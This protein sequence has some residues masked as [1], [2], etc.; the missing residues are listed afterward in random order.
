[1]RKVGVWIDHTR[2]VVAAIDEGKET[3]ETVESHVGRH[4]KPRGGAGT[5]TPWAPRSPDREHQRERQYEQHLVRFYQEVIRHLGRPG[6]LLIFGPARAKHEL[7]EELE[8][9]LL[10]AVPTVL[11]TTDEMTDAQVMARV[12]KF[13]IK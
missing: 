11:E 7:K 13:E 2:A 12:R 3:L 10:R 8:D 5:S 6:Q 1:M 9:S 4:A